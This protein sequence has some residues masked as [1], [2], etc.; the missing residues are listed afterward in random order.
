MTVRAAARVTVPLCLSQQRDCEVAT[1]LTLRVRP[2]Q[3]EAH[4]ARTETQ[5]R[6]QLTLNPGW[7]CETLKADEMCNSRKLYSHWTGADRQE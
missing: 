6:H 4:S 1:V 7:G 3:D 2:S 5:M